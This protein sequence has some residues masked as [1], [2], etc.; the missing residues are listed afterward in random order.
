MKEKYTKYTPKN[1]LWFKDVSIKD[2]PVVGG[3]GASL[4]EMFNKFPIPN[5]FCITVHGYKAFLDETGIGEHLHGLLDRL[6][7]E[8][9]D[10]LDKVSQDIRNLILKQKFPSELRKE[11]INNYKKIKGKVAVRS[12]ATAEDLPKA[13]FAGQQDTYLNIKGEENIIKAV[14][15]CW[16][17]LFTSRAIYYREKNNF[18][19]RNV[20]ISVVIQKMVDADFAGVMFTVDPVNKK[21][22][23]IEI[24]KGLGEALVS[25]QVTPNSYFL[26]K[27][28]L[29]IFEK[30]ED[31]A[32]DEKL[33][34]EIGKVG[35]KI[36]KHY[37][38]PMDVELAV[39]DKKIYI[40]QARPI[41]T[42]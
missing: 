9:T 39:K 30:E 19:H 22:L 17:S 35:M 10:E 36:E 7:V 25:G 5:G 20:L 2:I 29:E 34:K 31:F 15:K 12:S 4:G 38:K 32:F 3:K 24:V 14:H 37:K 11:I 28:K 27:P 1:I 40:L 23:L 21:Y 41:T 16:A 26:H 8:K 18:H 6:H 42:L 33:L 13:S